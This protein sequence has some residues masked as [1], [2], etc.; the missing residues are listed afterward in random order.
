MELFSIFLLV[1]IAIRAVDASHFRGAMITW[2][3]HEEPNKVR[4]TLLDKHP[5]TITAPIAIACKM[6]GV[7]KCYFSRLQT[8][9]LILHC[10][11]LEV[12]DISDHSKV[13]QSVHQFT[14]AVNGHHEGSLNST[15]MLK[16][17]QTDIH[18]HISNLRISLD[19]VGQ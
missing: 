16:R 7:A 15:K 13:K 19:V 1:Y 12:Q 3:P 2:E 4:F 5:T 6:V 11:F 8:T 18:T 9:W 10:H 17:G 14:D